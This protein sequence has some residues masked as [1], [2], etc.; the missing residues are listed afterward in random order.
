MS[1]YS[2]SLILISIQDLTSWSENYDVYLA[3]G[4]AGADSDDTFSSGVWTSKYSLREAFKKSVT[5]LTLGGG[6]KIGLRFSL[7]FFSSSKSW[8]KMA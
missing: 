8:S 5:F 1:A 3:A 7:H 4:S 2:T 6:V